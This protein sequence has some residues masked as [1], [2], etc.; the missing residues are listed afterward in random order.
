MRRNDEI[1]TFKTRISLSAYAAGQGFTLD[2]K[3][4]SRNS[5][6]M[7]SNSDK[8]V[9][10]KASD[11]HWIYFSVH[12]DNDNGSIIDFVQNRQ[13]LNLGQVRKELRPWIGQG[14]L[15]V[16]S[17]HINDQ[18]YV[19]D[20]E[21]LSKDI[22]RVRA[23]FAAMKLVDSQHR[24]LENERGILCATLCS[25]RF[26]G[27]IYIDKHKNAV[28]PH[29]NRDGVCGFEIRNVTF[30]GFAVGGEKGLWS[31]RI[32]KDDDTLVIGESAIDLLSYAQL[33]PKASA[34]YGHT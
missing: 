24:Y 34:R 22:C 30:K 18:N 29:F 27:R 14:A 1:E 3:S 6:V 33:H 11:Q 31:S 5:V 9:I 23:Q 10:A 32:Q 15:P 16:Y 13:G 28:F 4:S 21:P 7:R 12:D 26:A 8:V 17:R 20:L 25:D 19:L 2:R